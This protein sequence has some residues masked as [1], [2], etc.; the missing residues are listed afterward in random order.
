[1]TEPDVPTDPSSSRTDSVESFQQAC[2]SLRT[3][4]DTVLVILLVLTWSVNI[5]LLKQLSLVRNEVEERQRFIVD[6]EKNTVPLMGEFL[7]RLQR[8]TKTNPDFTN[9]LHKYWMP[10]NAAAGVPVSP[11]SKVKK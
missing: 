10:T 9:I 2:H 3:L 5:F 11:Q 8:F 1:M 7:T 6:Y 4:I